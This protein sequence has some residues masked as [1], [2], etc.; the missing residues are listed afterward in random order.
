MRRAGWIA[1]V[2]MVAAMVASINIVNAVL[3]GE[4]QTQPHHI[5]GHIGLALPAAVLWLWLRARRGEGGVFLVSGRV[6]PR[7]LFVG[8]GLFSIGACVE[9][10]SAALGQEGFFNVTHEIGWTLNAVGMLALLVS[11]VLALS[12]PMFHHKAHRDLPDE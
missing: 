1:V 4:P 8:L 5:S 2:L 7:V 3:Q 6:F 9:A 12:P 10:A 11:V